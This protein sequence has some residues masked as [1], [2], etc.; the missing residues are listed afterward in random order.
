[1]HSLHFSSFP[2]LSYLNSD[3]LGVPV[4]SPPAPPASLRPLSPP[5]VGVSVAGDADDA[6]GPVRRVEAPGQLG[7]VQ[8]V[9]R[10]R[11]R[12][13]LGVEIEG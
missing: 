6:A 10:H 3:V 4:A 8:Q 13:S 12:P 7:Q 9:R 11:F 2:L 5:E 1:M